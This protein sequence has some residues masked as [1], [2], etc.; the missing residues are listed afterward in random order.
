MTTYSLSTAT[1]AVLGRVELAAQR[2]ERLAHLLDQL[3]GSIPAERPQPARGAAHPLPDVVERL[4]AHHDLAGVDVDRAR[5]P[6]EPLA[7]ALLL[8][9]LGRGLDAPG[10]AGANEQAMWS[11]RPEKPSGAQAV[12][13]TVPPGFTTRNISSIGVARPGREDRAEARER[14]V[15]AVVLER[16]VLGVGLEPLDVVALAPRC[17]PC[18]GLTWDAEMSVA[19]TLAPSRAAAR[20]TLPS[21]AATSSISCPAETAQASTRCCAAGSSIRPMKS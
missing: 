11:R 14:G 20:A 18:R 5:Q 4:G 10:R 19:T 13:P 9:P 16:Q 3:R 7:D 12:R 1:A 15:E 2:L 17:A 21:P 8:A 6:V